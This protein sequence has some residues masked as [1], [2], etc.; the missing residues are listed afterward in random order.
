L[1][2]EAIV[3]ERHSIQSVVNVLSTRMGGPAMPL[4][5]EQKATIAEVKQLNFKDMSIDEILAQ[6]ESL[7]I[8]KFMAM[9]DTFGATVYKCLPMVAARTEGPF[10]YDPEGKRYFDMLACYGAVNQGHRHPKI[11]EAV[12]KQ[13]DVVTLSSRAYYSDMLAV[14]SKFVTDFFGYDRVLPMN[15]G[16]EAAETAVKV[17][18]RWAYYKKKVPENEAI[19]L[20][21]ENNFWGR[22]VTAVSTSVNP[23]AFG[24]YGPF[25]P[26]FK[27]IP[28]DDIPALE[29][30][31]EEDGPRIAAYMVEPIQGEAGVY[32]P[33]A[34]YLKAAYD[35][36]KKHNV[37]FVADEI[38]TG[39]GRTGKMICCEHDG[40]RPD[41]LC[42][43]KSLSGGVS[44]VSCVLADDEVML[45]ITYGSHGS[46]YGGNALGCVAAVAS[47]CVLRDEKLAENAEK[48][49]KVFRDEM[50]KVKDELPWI[51]S[52]RGKG[53]MNCVEIAPG[54]VKAWEI[55]CK[56]VEHGV[57]AKPTH[58]TNIRFSPPL[59]ITEDQMREAIVI[60][61]SVLRSFSEKM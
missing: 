20:F 21:P 56:L 34:G 8:K 50:M 3:A 49:G 33:S 59:V 60:I 52:V 54:N 4:T 28:F 43:A 45:N 46:T 32:V 36:C 55:C 35:L 6:R 13:L 39:L 2:H 30:V 53:L 51:C 57:L 18:R 1:R 22:S 23:D 29:K 17:S 10:I 44:P 41:V 58:E 15:S 12:K 37:L 7:N 40:V 38:Q 16:C 26:G 19:I 31:L 14:Y 24:S 61:S 42:L 5:E 9:D 47:L 48:V 27:I 11:I 25:T